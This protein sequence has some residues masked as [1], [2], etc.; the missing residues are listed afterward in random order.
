MFAL[1]AVRSSDGI[2]R[3]QRRSKND[4]PLTVEN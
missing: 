1:R 3:C 2:F 4:P